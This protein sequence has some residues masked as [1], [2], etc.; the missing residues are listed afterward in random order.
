MK[1]LLLLL[2][3]SLLAS[4]ATDAQVYS[5]PTP[6]DHKV[7]FD[8]RLLV[9]CQKPTDLVDNPRKSD[10]LKQNAEDKKRHAECY[11][12]NQMLIRAVRKAF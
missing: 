7:N 8:E 9:E 6:E 11:K 4:C 2:V 3:T 5:M 10:V 1:T 12:Q